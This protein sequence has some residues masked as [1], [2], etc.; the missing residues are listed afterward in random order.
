MLHV[1]L[2]AMLLA[3]TPS[4]DKTVRPI[5]EQHCQP[6]HFAGG[7]MYARLPFDRAE[8]IVKLGPKLFTRIRN[9]QERAVIRKYLAATN[10]R[11][12]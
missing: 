4:Y 11:K 3:Q 1:A 10:S 5:L 2:L 6:C 8:T 9:E 12:N 7:K